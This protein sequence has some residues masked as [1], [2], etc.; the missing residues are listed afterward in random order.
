[1]DRVPSP[2]IAFTRKSFYG[3]SYKWLENLNPVR[4]TKVPK[5]GKT[6]AQF[7]AMTMMFL[8][9]HKSIMA[10]LSHA[11][12]RAGYVLENTGDITRVFVEDSD[13]DSNP[14]TG[15]YN[16]TVNKTCNSC[17]FYLNCDVVHH[18]CKM[19]PFFRDM[20]KVLDVPEEEE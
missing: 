7:N 16:T 18:C 11:L 5:G 17:R 15:V 12:Q 10:A 2:G 13:A 3:C 14:L 8:S 19:E 4:A 20:R 1:V 9:E 6:M